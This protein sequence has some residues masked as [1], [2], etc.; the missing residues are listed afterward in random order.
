MGAQ[1]ALTKPLDRKKRRV[2]SRAAGRRSSV[3]V[4]TA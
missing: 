3:V 4:L 1:A 2:E